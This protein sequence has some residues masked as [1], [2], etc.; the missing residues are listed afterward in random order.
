[1]LIMCD[2]LYPI[3][4]IKLSNEVI[5]NNL[6]GNLGDEALE[7]ISRLNERNKTLEVSTQKHQE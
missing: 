4:Y 5:Q 6:G 7:E 2:L 1:M 3:R